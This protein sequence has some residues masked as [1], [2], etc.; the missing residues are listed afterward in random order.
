LPEALGDQRMNK[1]TSSLVL[2]IL[3]ITLACAFPGRR[4]RLKNIQDPLQA[5]VYLPLA[6]EC[7]WPSMEFA[8][9]PETCRLKMNS[10]L[11]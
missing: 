2:V 10:G 11:K 9:A 8:N 3:R 6:R 1:S 7:I 5:M 4:M